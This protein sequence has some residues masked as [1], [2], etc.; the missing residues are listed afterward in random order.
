MNTEPYQF[1]FLSDGG[2]F[3]WTLLGIALFGLV[4]L[5]E[6]GLYLHR[7]QIPS[8]EFLSGIFNNLRKG[9]YIEALTVCENTEGPV[10]RVVK[11]I[12][13]HRTESEERMRL[14]AEEAAIAEIPA[15]E[16]RAGTIN[17]FAKIAPLVG[18]AGTV[19]ALLRAFLHMTAAGHY[20]TADLFSADIAQ[21]LAA[22]GLGLVIAIVLHLG[23][24]FIVGRIRALTYDIDKTAIAVIL[25]LNYEIHLP[26]TDESA[27]SGK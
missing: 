27:E 4:F 26:E 19:F 16:R 11:A 12:L 7:R 24:H 1:Y 21:A 2:P 25:F 10:A 6:R 15:L 13:L 8:R 9:R 3:V 23:H 17:A 22:T 20:A 14:A 18:L 5:I